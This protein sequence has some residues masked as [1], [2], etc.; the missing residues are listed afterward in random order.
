MLVT[1]PQYDVSSTSC[2]LP[3]AWKLCRQ[4]ICRSSAITQAPSGR[5]LVRHGQANKTS[6]LAQSNPL[7]RRASTLRTLPATDAHVFPFFFWW[8][9]GDVIESRFVLLSCPEVEKVTI[10]KRGDKS[11]FSEGKI[12]IYHVVW[13]TG[14]LQALSAI[15]VTAV[16]PSS[17]PP[18]QP[19]IAVLLKHLEGGG[20]NSQPRS[21]LL[22]A[23]DR[24]EE[25][26]EPKQTG[27]AFVKCVLHINMYI[28][29]RPRVLQFSF[30]LALAKLPLM[31]KTFL[32]EWDLRK[33]LQ[34]RLRT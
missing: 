10:W 2:G 31:L 3:G 29:Y 16:L 9:L 21:Q 30:N 27:E 34:S 17:L 26:N 8:W 32:P 14:M 13:G 23:V 4:C 11:N 25:W 28:S 24:F 22:L 20:G 33:D 6:K 15:T 5:I 12:V 1:F 19:R 18:A 7:L